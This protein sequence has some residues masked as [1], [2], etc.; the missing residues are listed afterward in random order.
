[1]VEDVV[2]LHDLRIA[3]KELRYAAELF[4][5]AL[6]SDLAAMAEPAAR[7]QKRLGEI[8]DVDVALITIRRTR[9]LDVAT[10]PD[11]GQHLEAMRVKKVRK[12]SSEMAPSAAPS[13]SDAAAEE[14]SGKT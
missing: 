5:P 8:H 1:P 4:A 9:T 3:Y 7:F 10:R 14:I 12:Y 2:G 11:A 13:T 6:P